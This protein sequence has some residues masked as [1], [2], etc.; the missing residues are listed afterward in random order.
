[1]SY[2]PFVITT[3][4]ATVAELFD[5]YL[6]HLEARGA[7]CY[8]HMI[9]LLSHAKEHIG[10][11]KKASEIAPE[12]ICGWLGIIYSRGS[13][14]MADR[15]RAYLRAV[16]SWGMMAANDY[17]NP[18]SVNWGIRKNPVDEIKADHKASSRVRSRF[19]DRSE[20]DR[21]IAQLMNSIDNQSSKVLLL[22]LLIGCRIEEATKLKASSYNSCLGTIH[23]DI[24]KTGK[25][26]QVGLGPLAKTL[27]DG[28][29]AGKESEQNIFPGIKNRDLP[30]SSETV[31]KHFRKFGFKDASPRDA[32]RRSFKT[33]IRSAGVSIEIANIIQQHSERSVSY[34]HYDR[35]ALTTEAALQMSNALKMWEEWLLS[36]SQGGMR[37]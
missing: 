35:Y 11:N 34:R 25:P 36:N 3:Q 5:G 9:S 22:A 10:A 4:K 30:I 16:W 18:N 20:L 17:R 26:H 23:W 1:M 7:S 24:T 21:F 2:N 19:L 12:E 14:S 29:C 13:A 37:I 32:C 28:W 27:M 8:D 33:H 15:A 31:F 6:A